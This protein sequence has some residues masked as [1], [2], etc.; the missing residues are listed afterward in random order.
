MTLKA[1]NGKSLSRRLAQD[2]GLHWGCLLTSLLRHRHAQRRPWQAAWERTNFWPLRHKPGELKWLCSVPAPSRL[3]FETQTHLFTM[4][5]RLR[6]VSSRWVLQ[7]QPFYQMGPSPCIS[8]VYIWGP[9]EKE[10]IFRGF[11][12]D[13]LES[14]ATL[15]RHRGF[16]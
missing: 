4:T 1:N 5:W 15:S 9:S 6:V 13:D 12:K 11:R 8:T 10:S 3:L 7:G 2:Q 16:P 14:M